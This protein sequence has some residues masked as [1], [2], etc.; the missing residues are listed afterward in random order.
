MSG[1]SCDGLDLAYCDFSY[2][3]NRWDYNILDSLSIPY[4]Q[5][6]STALKDSFFAS[7]DDLLALDQEFSGFVADALIDFHDSIKLKPDLIAFHGHTVFHRPL[8]SGYS[9]QL[10]SGAKIAAR[11]G[12]DTICDFRNTDIALGGQGAPLVP[13]G[14]KYLFPDYTYCLNLG[15]FANI[16]FDHKGK[17]MAFDI[18]PVNMA[19]NELAQFKGSSYDENGSW[20]ANGSINTALLEILE[21]QEF[22]HKSGPKSLGREWY[23]AIFR[24]EVSSFDIPVDDK[25][26]TLCEH[27]ALRIKDSIPVVKGNMLITGGGAYNTFLVDRISE[28]LSKK[29][30]STVIPDSIIINFKEALIFAFLGIL[31]KSDKI[32]TLSSVTGASHDSSGGCIYKGI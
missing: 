19:L 21:N 8:N 12:V 11:T 23:E 24:E 25:L 28:H 9:L 2:S 30:V 3:N 17:R 29:G 4:Q 1:T 15:G 6:L 18:C 7:R 22:Y 5:R 10:G 13:I 31:R 27:A 20:A 16:S 14:D 26:A 32:N